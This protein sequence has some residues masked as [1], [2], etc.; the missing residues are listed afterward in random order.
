LDISCALS[1]QF[2]VITGYGFD[3]GVRLKFD[4][5]QENSNFTFV[6]KKD[7]ELKNVLLGTAAS[8]LLMCQSGSSA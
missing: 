6:V 8:L 7:L 3:G 2:S 1:F 4:S 5:K